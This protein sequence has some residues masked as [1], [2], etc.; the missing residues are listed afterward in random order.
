MISV[1]LAEA[2]EA[3]RNQED[4]FSYV[5]QIFVLDISKILNISCR[6]YT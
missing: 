3:V 4:R 2:M 6:I 1:V 5:L